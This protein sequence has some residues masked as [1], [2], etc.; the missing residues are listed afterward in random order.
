MEN[1][2]F[3]TA[4]NIGNNLI[5]STGVSLIHVLLVDDDQYLQTVYKTLF[6]VGNFKI[7]AQ[8]FDGLEAIEKYKELDP[9][10]DVVLMD[11][12]MPRMDGISATKLLKEIDP[13]VKIV[14]LSADDESRYVAFQAGASAFLSKPV[15]I[16]LLFDTIENVVNS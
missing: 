14:F 7:T 2:I 8:A 6:A 11:Q 10:P 3:S 12:R 1:H 4:D 9:K 13:D 5:T 16:E 15:R